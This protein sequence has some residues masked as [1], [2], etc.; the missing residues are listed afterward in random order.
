MIRAIVL[1]TLLLLLGTNAAH[2]APSCTPSSTGVAFGIFRGALLTTVGSVRLTCTGTG[3]G[4][5]NYTLMLSTGSSAAY[6]TRTMRNGASSLSYN[7]FRDSARTQIWGNGIGGSVTVTGQVQMKGAPSVTV[8][9]PIYGRIPAQT[10]PAA[11]TY[12][13]A[14]IAT[15]T[16]SNTTRA[17]SFLVTAVI[18]TGCSISATNL[19]FGSYSGTQLDGQS[20]VSVSCTTGLPWNVG[21]NQ[22]TRPGA[23]VATRRMTGPGVSS[24]SYSLFRNSAR[25]LN[26]GNTVGTDTVSGTGTG[27]PQS[28]TVFGRVPGSQNLP[29]GGYQDTIVATITF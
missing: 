17:T 26:W 7:L 22:G 24:M 5:G 19:V 16:I 1:A 12:S 10:R 25:T 4:N 11:G 8:D 3:T 23:T 21:L 15:L 6:A 2:A 20:Q 14:I 27:S 9:V 13:D 29:P 18:Q 28:L